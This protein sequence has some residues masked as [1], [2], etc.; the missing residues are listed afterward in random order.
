MGKIIYIIGKSSTGKDTI[1]NHILNDASLN[2]KPIVL[3]TTRPIRDGEED[4]VT[5]HFTNEDG[6]KSFE[7]AG[8]VIENRLYKTV[9]GDWRYFTV[10]DGNINLENNSYIVIGVLNSYVSFVE[11]FGRQSLV[12][13]LVEVE[14]GER[15]S[16]A[17]EREKRPENRKFQELCRRFLADSE[18]F[19]EDKI[20]AAGICDENRVE[21]DNLDECIRKIKEI[22]AGELA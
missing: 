16:R 8:K 7:D 12:P 15:L 6:F 5:Y 4:G 9:H 11:Y 22:I 21:N 19:S 17:L 20:L 2:L 14:D 1:Y 3:Y 13:I 18:D 10:D